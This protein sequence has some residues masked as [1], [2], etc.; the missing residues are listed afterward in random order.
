MNNR[1]LVS[2]LTLVIL[3]IA[4]YLVFGNKPAGQQAAALKSDAANQVLLSDKDIATARSSSLVYPLKIV[5]HGGGVYH[6]S[7]YTYFIMDDFDISSTSNLTITGLRFKDSSYVTGG[8]SS[9]FTVQVNGVQCI[10]SSGI[11]DLNNISIPVTSTIINPVF[12]VQLLKVSTG[13][14]PSGT[15]TALLID[16]I[17]AIDS[18]G[19]NI[20]ICDS[21]CTYQFDPSGSTSSIELMLVGGTPLVSWSPVTL[22]QFDNG[23]QLINTFTVYANRNITLNSFPLRILNTVPGV[24]YSDFIVKDN[25]GNIIPTSTIYSNPSTI[26]S[27]GSPQDYVISF[28]RPFRMHSEWKTFEVYVNISGFTNPSGAFC[29]R[30]AGSNLD[31]F[32]WTDTEGGNPLPFTIQNI[33]YLSVLTLTPWICTNFPVAKM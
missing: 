18:S 16:H 17:D 14:V 30:F 7:N 1:T 13:Q 33:K 29:S 5:G 22:D 3:V 11:C 27:I 2:L 10:F 26:S 15:A 23:L 28:K 4:G 21:G 8:P 25:L 31:K 19:N 12:Y 32:S 20:S 6:S 24:K 9:V